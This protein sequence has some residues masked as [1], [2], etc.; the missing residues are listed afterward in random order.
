MT[1]LTKRLHFKRI[2]SYI[3]FL[4]L[5]IC[6]TFA[7]SQQNE[8]QKA[9]TDIQAIQTR[10][11]KGD[12]K[13]VFRTVVSVLQD[14]KFKILFTDANT[15]VVS[16]EGTPQAAENMSQGA[17]AIGDIFLGGLLSLG[18]TEE[19]NKWTVSSNVEELSKNRGVLVRLVIVHETK[20]S[21]F[22][23]SADEKIKSN[24]LTT[25]RPEVYQNLFAKI[26]QA[27]FI[28]DAVK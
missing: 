6:P 20:K 5:F 26:E 3:F 21:G 19:E 13:Q 2:F 12:Y 11:F 9:S 27:L 23:V 8:Q 7:F 25:T 4:T 16:A 17:A 18:R 22:F 1:L 24:D 28:K 14:N 10:I 15:G